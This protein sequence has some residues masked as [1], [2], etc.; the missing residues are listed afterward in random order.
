MRYDETESSPDEDEEWSVVREDVALAPEKGYREL[1]IYHL[2]HALGVAAHH[3]S[4]RLPKHELYET[5]SQ[6]R[7]AAKSVSSNLVEGYGRRRYK[8]DYLRFLTYAKASLDET[9]EHLQYILDCHPNQEEAAALLQ[10]ADRLGRK[11]H[12]FIAL[13]EANHRV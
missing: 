9:E 12:R 4:L 8:A 11:F 5:G 3:L 2:A 10:S 1:R 6:L 13:V 7:R